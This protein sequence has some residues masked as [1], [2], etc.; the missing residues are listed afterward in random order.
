VRTTRLEGKWDETAAADRRRYRGNGAKQ[1]RL[2]LE[3]IPHC[4]VCYLICRPLESAEHP[5]PTAV[6][7]RFANGEAAAR[8]RRDTSPNQN[9]A[10]EITGI[11]DAVRAIALGILKPKIRGW[12]GDAEYFRR[13]GD[14]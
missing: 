2:F 1:H 12:V 11:S 3:Y 13:F 4:D 5:V 8:R 14:V 9:A 6:D 10:H 7:V